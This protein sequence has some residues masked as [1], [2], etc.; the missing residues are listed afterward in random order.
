[1]QFAFWI[2]AVIATPPA[3]YAFSRIFLYTALRSAPLSRIESALFADRMFFILYAMLAAA[4]LAALAWE[5]LFPDHT[6]QQ[7]LGA[8]PV[9]PRTVAAARLA[10]ALAMASGF[11]AAIGVPTALLFAM[12]ATTSPVMGF[13]PTVVAAHILATIGGAMFVFTALL[14]VRARSPS[15]FGADAAD[16][17]ALLL[18]FLTVLALVEVFFYLPW[19]CRFSCARCS[20]ATRRG[21][22][23]RRSGLPRSTRPLSAHATSSRRNTPGRRSRRS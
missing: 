14:V 6:D 7:A 16:R 12:V 17:L 5:A 9:R 11:A 1:M 8:L 20:Q 19:C 21:V 4:L 10:A 15:S 3:M 18:Q 13:L 23:F 2:V 22:C